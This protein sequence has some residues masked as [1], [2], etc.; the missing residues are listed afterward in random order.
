MTNTFSFFFFPRAS[1]LSVGG[2]EA[3][4]VEH[5]GQVF[6]LVNCRVGGGPFP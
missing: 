1:G 5:R 3:G 2:G 4:K 6:D